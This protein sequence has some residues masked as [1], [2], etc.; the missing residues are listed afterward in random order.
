MLPETSLSSV[1]LVSSVKL[2]FCGMKR[3]R[4][5]LRALVS[6]AWKSIATA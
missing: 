2:D 5:I 1:A 3:G 4:Y 6:E